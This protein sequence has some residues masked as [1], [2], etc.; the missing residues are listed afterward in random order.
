[1]PLID[2]SNHDVLLIYGHF[3]KKIKELQLIEATPGNPIHQDT[4][5]QDIELYSSIT[6]KI[7]KSNPEVIKLRELM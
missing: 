3:M 1:M 7:E 4:L 6:A 5:K 2:F